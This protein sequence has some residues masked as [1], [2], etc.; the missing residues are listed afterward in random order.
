MLS[1]VVLLNVFGG[2]VLAHRAERSDSAS[3]RLQFFAGILLVVGLLLLGAGLPL[4]RHNTFIAPV[5][6][7]LGDSVA[8]T[9]AAEQTCP[10][11]R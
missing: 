5:P 1:A 2:A 11:P 8:A 3:P 6:A 7:P 9:E 4:F 10:G